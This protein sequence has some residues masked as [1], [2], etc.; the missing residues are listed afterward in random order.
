MKKYVLEFLRRGMIACGFGPLVLAI[1]F[2]VLRHQALVE[3][4]PVDQVCLGIF[5]VSALAFVA[6]GLNVLYQIERIPLMVAILLHGGILYFCYLAVYLMNGWLQSSVKPLL[7]FTVIF[8]LGYLTVWA[9]IYSITKKKTA[10]INE[11]LKKNHRNAE[12]SSH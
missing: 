12:D 1:V 8:I 3:F 10:R 6:G 4:L 9:V 11:I 5:S 7:V 2:L